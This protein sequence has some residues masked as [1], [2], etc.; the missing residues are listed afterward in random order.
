MRLC[1][2]EPPPSIANPRPPK[3]SLGEVR[4]PQC[5]RVAG[6]VL[7]L[8]WSD[9]APTLE[10]NGLREGQDDLGQKGSEDVNR[11]GAA[12]TGVGSDVKAAK[13]KGAASGSIAAGAAAAAAASSSSSRAPLS[14]K[15]ASGKG[16]GGPS[17][18]SWLAC[19]F[20]PPRGLSACARLAKAGI[21]IARGVGRRADAL[22]RRLDELTA[23]SCP[24]C[25]ARGEEVATTAGA[26]GKGKGKGAEGAA[27][28]GL[29][30]PLLLQ[31]G[32]KQVSLN[33]RGGAG[34]AAAAVAVASAVAL[35]SA[36]S[37]GPTRRSF[38]RSRAEMVQ[39]ALWRHG[40]L[41]CS[42]CARFST[43]FA[44][45]L[46]VFPD[47]QELQNHVDARHAR[48]LFCQGGELAKIDREHDRELHREAMLERAAKNAVRQSARTAPGA[49][50]GEAPGGGAG[51]GS[52]AALASPS[53][54]F[55]DVEVAF[56]YR[57]VF[58]GAF[59]DTDAFYV[60]AREVH[61][62]CPICA[63]N[64]SGPAEEL[65]RDR[66]ALWKHMTAR[67]FACQEGDCPLA[68]VAFETL[69]EL[70]NHHLLHHAR[71][72]PK[73]DQKHARTLD[74]S[75]LPT[76]S[77]GGGGGGAGAGG[78]SGLGRQD[79][80]LRGAAG[81]G[82]GGGGGH[83]YGDAYGS[84]RGGSRGAAGA[85]G[86]NSSSHGFPQ[87]L[88]HGYSMPNLPDLG[89]RTGGGRLSSRSAARLPSLEDAYPTLDGPA[90][91]SGLA[92]GSHGSVAA[93]MGGLHVY[94]DDDDEDDTAAAHGANARAL[95]GA[96]ASASLGSSGVSS[97]AAATP[98]GLASS[99][100]AA[101]RRARAAPPPLVKVT[102]RCKC[103]RRA[104]HCA[105]VEGEA[106][107]ALECDAVCAIEGR[108]AAL[109]DA[110]GVGL[111]AN[112]ASSSTAAAASSSADGATTGS[113][114]GASG[115]HVVSDGLFPPTS[116]HHVSFPAPTAAFNRAGRTRE[117]QWPA[118]AIAA[119]RALP[120]ATQA[121][122]RQLEAFVAQPPSAS[123]KETLMPAPKLEREL[124]HHLAK[125]YGLASA[126]A[127]EGARRAVTVL[128][129]PGA[130]RPARRLSAAAASVDPREL[131]VALEAEKGHALRFYDVAP[132]ADPARSLRDWQGKVRLEWRG[133]DDV[134]AYFEDAKDRQAAKDLLGGGIRGMFRI[135]A[136]WTPAAQLD[137]GL[138]AAAGIGPGAASGSSSTSGAATPV[139]AAWGGA[140]AQA[141]GSA[142]G[143][144]YGDS[145]AMRWG[146]ARP[147]RPA[148]AAASAP[149]WGEASRT[150]ANGTSGGGGGG[151][152]GSAG[153]A[154]GW[155]VMRMP[156]RSITTKPKP[157][158]VL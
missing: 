51:S 152:S 31:Q 112:G 70:R 45:E 132:A 60:H 64:G 68:L 114:A 63:R 18:S 20:A 57:R 37:P 44:R 98:A 62:T 127:G 150:Q 158:G 92:G 141:S 8:E 75:N 97:A 77:G 136:A 73:W 82:G 86:Q 85:Y 153:N 156:T 143:R 148:S 24:T 137:R 61:E 47:L 1:V 74:L 116:A 35:A 123:G 52:A 138:A 71:T 117:H 13:A 49:I 105:V 16:G 119:A 76:H 155:T 91:G 65:H 96:G 134:V 87:G 10:A 53:S 121:L 54:P 11:D 120:R 69:D 59:Y 79:V 27:A 50:G 83:S 81:G 41:L 58:A 99:A 100:A 149:R 84:A 147:A 115:G 19:P 66:K 12:S 144:N 101:P 5:T 122:E 39:H 95:S 9:V 6:G 89:A 107:P 56:A 67:H 34:A 29:P 94:D 88:S 90:A 25:K 40:T 23:V 129:T 106:P 14:G 28:S 140:G 15:P 130:A 17:A 3:P 124:T 110:F 145:A 4:C 126:S 7:A 55:A 33:G 154:S 142:D 103:G 111:G 46:E 151:G 36:A 135:D 108:R 26:K 104:T 2:P 32:G 102:V 22:C 139:H 146:D 133:P 72:M 118:A 80:R 125:G 93:G 131:A 113:T 42:L 109:A 78:G 43:R 128:R 21:Y 38:F 30:T 157:D 48:C